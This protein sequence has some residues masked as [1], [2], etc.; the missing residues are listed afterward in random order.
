MAYETGG[1]PNVPLE[2]VQEV[3]DYVAAMNYGLEKLKEIPISIRLLKEVH[4]VLLRKGRGSNQQPGELR[5]TQNWIGGTRPGNAVFVPPPVDHLIEC[6]GD[7]ET[8]LHTDRLQIP[9]LIKAA[10]AHAQFETIHPFL[11]GNGRLG[12]L[13]ITLLLC[14]EGALREPMLYLSL[15]FKGHREEYYQLLQA[16]RLTGDWEAW[17]RFFLNAVTETASQAAATARSLTALA[18][19]DGQRIRG[20]GKAA[21]SVLRVHQLLQ[22]Q[23]LISVGKASQELGLSVPTVTSSLK[24]LEKLRVV[25]EITGRKSGRL[26]AYAEYLGLLQ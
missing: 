13:L 17:V 3:S 14:A 24:H 6:L 23:P 20:I 26:Y 9:V 8:F 21:G 19:Q 10:L 15:Y 1:V 4:G 18:V 7:L 11:D 16:V 12:R 22:R 25:Q 2:D 5:R